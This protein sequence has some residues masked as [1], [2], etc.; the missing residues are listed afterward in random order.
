MGLPFGYYLSTRSRLICKPIMYIAASGAR[1]TCLNFLMNTF[2]TFIGLERS[3]MQNINFFCW[4]CSRATENQGSFRVEMLLKK[5]SFGVEHVENTKKNRQKSKTNEQV[6]CKFRI[7]SE[8][9]FLL[10][11]FGTEIGGLLE[12]PLVN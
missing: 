4:G 6:Y 1:R 12:L 3:D 2:H 8:L 10:R 5:R 9:I 11:S 7:F